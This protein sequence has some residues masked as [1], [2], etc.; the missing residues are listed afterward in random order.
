MK[1]RQRLKAFCLLSLLLAA[2]TACS[3]S[4]PSQSTTLPADG[5]VKADVFEDA[6]KNS[7]MLTFSG[8]S[9][10]ISYSWFFDG[11]SIASVADQ[12]L[13]VDFQNADKD[14]D[15]VI[16]ATEAVK[17]RLHEKNIIQAKTTLE[18][19][20]DRLWNAEQ[21]RIYQ[22]SAGAITFVREVP[23]NNGSATS[24][25]FPVS[26]ADG[27]FYIAAK[28]ASFQ[29]LPSKLIAKS[30]AQA[31]QNSSQTDSASSAQSA[32]KG[33]GD[34]TPAG[35]GQP[36]AGAFSSSAENPSPGTSSNSGNPAASSPGKAVEQSKD[37]YLTDPVP[38]GKPKPAEPQNNKVN[39]TKAYYCTLSIDC[40]T[41]LDNKENLKKE[42][43]S[44]LPQ[45]G[46]ILKSRKVVFYE[47]ES[48]FDVLL[49]ETKQRKIQMEYKPTPMYNSNYIEG[50]HN[51]YEFDCGELSGWMYEVNGWF[52]N[53]GCSRYQ[54]KDGD[55]VQ[56]RYTC[57]LGKDVGCDWDVSQK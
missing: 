11:G 25:T 28:D 23:L 26:S 14:L 17:L 36:L 1:I 21:A 57:D 51:L 53:Y 12:N 45:N 52:P 35:N 31:K 22:S 44:V 54:L 8:Q 42:K 13:K 10:G 55:S 16:K 5:I 32:P 39:K 37:Q 46:I 24:L 29:E 27:D 4:A 9:D 48:V 33:A 40:K 47:G 56:W 3:F 34:Q 2:L 18:I 19:R 20:L 41:I 6:M 43:E 7:K 15:G 30:P 38:Q 50:I 49:R